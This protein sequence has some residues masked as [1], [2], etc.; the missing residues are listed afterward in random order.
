MTPLHHRLELARVAPP[1]APAV[2]F[3][4]VPARLGAPLDLR[5][6]PFQAPNDRNAHGY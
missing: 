1:D 5:L 6:M 4:R 3:D 2:K